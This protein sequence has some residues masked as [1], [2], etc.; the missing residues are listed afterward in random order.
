MLVLLRPSPGTLAVTPE[1][2]ETVAEQLHQAKVTE[3]DHQEVV[4]G[5]MLL[6]TVAV[7]VEHLAMLL[8]VKEELPARLLATWE[9]AEHLEML[10]ATVAVVAEQLPT[11]LVAVGVVAHPVMLLVTMAVVAHPAMLQVAAAVAVEHLPMLLV[12]TVE[13]EE[14]PAMLLTTAEVVEEHLVYGCCSTGPP[15]DK[16]GAARKHPPLVHHGYRHHHR[17]RHQR[18]SEHSA[19]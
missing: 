8:G 6:I 17:H 13:V 15:A 11:L 2:L 12:P 1:R 4:V 7:A 5:Q 3:Q 14:H 18:P 10:L 19:I 9:V 16:L